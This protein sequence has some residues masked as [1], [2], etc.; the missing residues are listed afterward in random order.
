MD[1]WTIVAYVIINFI[2]NRIQA[3]E[4]WCYRKILEIKW[5]DRVKNSEVLRKIV[6][7]K[8]KPIESSALN[9]GKQN[10]IRRTHHVV[11]LF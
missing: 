8:K 2:S 10:G 11:I 7:E 9:Q 4:N 1:Q 6:K 3:F 5:S